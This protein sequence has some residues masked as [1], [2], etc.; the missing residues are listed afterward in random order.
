MLS[1]FPALCVA[2]YQ[3]QTISSQVFVIGLSIEE[4]TERIVNICDKCVSGF[5]H[6]FSAFGRV[7]A[8]EAE[9]ERVSKSDDG[10]GDVNHAT[11]GSGLQ[12][13]ES[14]REV[15][16]DTTRINVSQ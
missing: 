2:L 16:H 8:E 15:I 13:S 5:L 11:A 10:P 14:C 1:Y 9:S 12:T 7:S 3:K 4:T 6:F